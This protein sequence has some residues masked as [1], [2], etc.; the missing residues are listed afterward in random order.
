[1]SKSKEFFS[2]TER[3]PWPSVELEG[4]N[5]H[6]FHRWWEKYILPLNLKACE[7]AIEKPKQEHLSECMNLNLQTI[8]LS[9]KDLEYAINRIK[10]LS[11]GY[12]D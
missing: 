5:M 12:T 9:V 3:I 6:E 2:Q 10:E 1:M 7:D 11:S 8:I 4:A